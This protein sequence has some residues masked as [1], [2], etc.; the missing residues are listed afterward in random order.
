MI[1]SL[2]R[3]ALREPGLL[4]EHAAGYSLL[5]REELR[6][7]QRAVRRRARWWLVTALLGLV[8]LMLAGVALMLWAVTAQAHWLLWVVPAVPALLA[9]LSAGQ[10]ASL[11]PSDQD[12]QRLW[13]QLDTDLRM[14]QEL[15]E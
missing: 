14:I 8:A 9:L 6:A 5:A 7:W 4:A 11:P 10:A 15:N 2:I 12:F 13:A 1:P 3:L